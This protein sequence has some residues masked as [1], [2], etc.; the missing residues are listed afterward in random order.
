MSPEQ[1]IGSKDVDWKTDQYALGVVLYE[2]FSG[3]VPTGAVKSVDAMRNDVRIEA[4]RSAAA[5][6]R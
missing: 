2:L 5:Q 6:C 3:N 4:R 1:R